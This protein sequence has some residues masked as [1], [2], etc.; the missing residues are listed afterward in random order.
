MLKT[1]HSKSDALNAI[2]AHYGVSHI[3]VFGSVARGE[4]RPDSDVDL[5][6]QFDSHHF[7]GF[8]LG[9]FQY[10]ASTLLGRRVDIV[11]E[12]WAHPVIA[13]HMQQE[14]LYLVQSISIKDF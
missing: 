11:I 1:L 12:G 4:E 10:D 6:V 5:L 2:G 14:V 9:G 8:D 7:T 3:R 13:E